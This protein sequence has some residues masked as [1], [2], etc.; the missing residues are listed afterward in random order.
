MI[1]NKKAVTNEINDT[2]MKLENMLQIEKER[3][4]KECDNIAK[5][6]KT[7]IGKQLDFARLLKNEIQTVT[8]IYSFLKR[9]QK[10]YKQNHTFQKKKTVIAFFAFFGFTK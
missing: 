3:S 10:I 6:K 8:H 7:N 2:F 9:M 5:N 4:L 1:D